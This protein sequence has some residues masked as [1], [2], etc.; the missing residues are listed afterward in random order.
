MSSDF[1]VYNLEQ[2]QTKDTASLHINGELV[3][4]WRDW[5]KIINDPKM[6]YVN[7]IDAKQVKGPHI[8]E[9]RTSY[10]YCTDGKIVLVI[11]DSK[12]KYHEIKTDSN[13]PMLIEVSNGVAAA[14]INPTEEISRVLV[15]ADIAWKPGD[16]E[17]KNIKFNDYDWNKW[18]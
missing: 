2:H 4:I 13:Q 11:K 9:N 10:F 7:S 17:M 18:K 3:V 1:S 8:H 6:M 14:L 5:D 16:N 15:L 12:G